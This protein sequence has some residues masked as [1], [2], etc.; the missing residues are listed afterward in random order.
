MGRQ[1]CVKCDLNYERNNSSLPTPTSLKHIVYDYH[2]GK[3]LLWRSGM[4]IRLNRWQSNCKCGAKIYCFTVLIVLAHICQERR[5]RKET[6]LLLPSPDKV[7]VFFQQSSH[8]VLGLKMFMCLSDFFDWAPSRRNLSVNL[9]NINRLLVS[10]E[11][12]TSRTSLGPWSL[13]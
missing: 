7:A 9:I 5:G 1:S 11:H 12:P 4:P 3:S 10:R 13:R 2:R 6:L 8:S